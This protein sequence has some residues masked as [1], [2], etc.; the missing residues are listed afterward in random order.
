[1]AFYSHFI[2]VYFLVVKQPT[3]S[4]KYNKMN[5]ILTNVNLFSF[6]FG[7][8]TLIGSFRNQ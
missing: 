2:T 1:M 8:K 7:R 4:E 5:Q 6:H 3:Y